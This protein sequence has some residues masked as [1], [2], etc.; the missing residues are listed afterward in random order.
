MQQFITQFYKQ[1]NQGYQKAEQLADEP[2]HF[3]ISEKFLNATL[4]RFVVDN[5]HSWMKDLHLD[6]HDDWLRLY[7]TLEFGRHTHFELSVDL[8]LVEMKI[9]HHQQLFVFE[10][11]SD[12]QVIQARFP[13]KWQGWLAHSALFILQEIVQKDPLGWILSEKGMTFILKRPYKV[14]EIHNGLLHLDIMQWIG[15]N[16]AIINTLKKVNILDGSTSEQSLN[17]KGKIYLDEILNL[18]K[19]LS[20]DH[21]PIETDTIIS[22]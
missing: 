17:M 11:L 1:L 6:L 5:L 20:Y 15:K 9:N 2:R 19:I 12:T 7:T 8:R 21:A 16:K 13:Q 4:E 18:N 22:Q 14:V 3:S 10:Q